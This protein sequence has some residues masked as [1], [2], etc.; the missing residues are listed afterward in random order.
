MRLLWIFTSGYKKST[1]KPENLGFWGFDGANEVVS[2]QNMWNLQG[3][4][5]KETKD[6]TR[7]NQKRRPQAL[8]FLEAQCRKLAVANVHARAMEGGQMVK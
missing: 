6:A 7:A 3:E 1:K 5:V 4:Q 8:G 2:A